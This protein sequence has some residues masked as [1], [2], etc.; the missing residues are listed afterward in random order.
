MLRRAFCLRYYQTKGILSV[1]DF[2]RRTFTYVTV[3]YAALSFL[4]WL[5]QWWVN[6][7][8][9]GMGLVKSLLHLLLF[10]ALLLLPI[11]L[12]AGRTG[13]AL[14]L[15]PA[16]IGFLI[17]FGPFL[18]PST[19][20]HAP[21]RSLRL[22]TFNIQ[23]PT[24]GEVAN[25]IAI[26]DSTDADIV[27]IQELSVVASTHFEEYFSNKYPH[28]ALHPDEDYAGQGV[29]SRFPIQE[30]QYWRY[31]GLPGALGHQR[32]LLE[33]DGREVVLYNVHPVPPVT[34]QQ[35]LNAAPHRSA[36]RRLLDDMNQENAP[37]L[38]VG[39]LN[40]TDQFHGY[41]LL[42]ERYTDAFRAVGT[43][44][45]GFTFP[46]KQQVPLPPFLRLDYIFYGP[47]FVG[48]RAE[49]WPNTGSS[50]HASVVADL[51][52]GTRLVTKNMPL[53]EIMINE[54]TA[55]TTLRRSD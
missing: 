51:A 8:V 54:A 48:I 43:A 35:H 28:Q 46:Y 29:L 31:N 22:M 39:D 14:L 40:M 26:I 44:G 7:E 53:N 42:N 16:V 41:R 32:V 37:L 10:P 30:D 55:I 49:V 2:L 9:V 25:L 33:I 38:L 24:E 4:L 6:E 13:M 45:F 19:N 21:T 23:T 47:S 50:D 1:F 5:L 18:V 12:V 3:G 36:I 34:Y 15:A 52:F 11:C 20:E 27:A 17:S